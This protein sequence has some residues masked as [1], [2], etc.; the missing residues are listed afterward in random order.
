MEV[1]RTKDESNTLSGA[2]GTHGVCVFDGNM[3][4]RSLNSR[5]TQSYVILRNKS[6]SQMKAVWR[7]RVKAS[8]CSRHTF[9][10]KSVINRCGF[11]R[12]IFAFELGYWVTSVCIVRMPCFLQQT[13]ADKGS[14]MRVMN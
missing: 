13:I 2:H 4:V 8:L 14:P 9:L 7:E 10:C 5:H 11:S 6:K 12:L 3:I 1:V